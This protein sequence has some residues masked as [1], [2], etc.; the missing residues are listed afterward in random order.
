[1]VLQQ[2]NVILN[3]SFA[4]KVA[5]ISDEFTSCCFVIKKKEKEIFFKKENPQ[6][7]LGP[8][9]YIFPIFFSKKQH[10]KK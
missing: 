8:T 4:K 3:R 1:V 9:F 7:K 6:V 5:T 2:E 10:P